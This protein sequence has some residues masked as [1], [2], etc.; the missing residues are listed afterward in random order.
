MW[1][2]GISN[3]GETET[4]TNHSETRKTDVWKNELDI[5]YPE[6]TAY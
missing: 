6:Q 5:L 2:N 4:N 1:G 3:V